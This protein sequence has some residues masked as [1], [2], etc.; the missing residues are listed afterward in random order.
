MTNS[1]S[2][3]TLGLALACVAFTFTWRC[4]P[5]HRLS[6][7]YFDGTKRKRANAVIQATD[8]NLYGQLVALSLREFGNV[9]RVSPTGEVTSVYT[10]WPKASLCRRGVASNACYFGSDGNLYGV[11]SAVAPS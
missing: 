9:V 7:C 6:S 2:L 8:G 3:P 4:A 10:F 5:R 1:K 11:T